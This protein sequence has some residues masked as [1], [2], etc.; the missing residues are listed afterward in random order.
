MVDA[1][2][3]WQL[4]IYKIQ[5]KIDEDYKNVTTALYGNLHYLKY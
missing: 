1:I 2:N 5:N 4:N 3:Y